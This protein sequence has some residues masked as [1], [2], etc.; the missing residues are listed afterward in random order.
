MDQNLISGTLTPDDVQACKDALDVLFTKMPFLSAMQNVDVSRFFKVG[1]AYQPLLDLAMQ[2]VETH[3]EILPLI[4]DKEEFM[5]DS[6]LYAALEP[7]SMRVSEL[8]TGLDK[9]VMAVGS[10][11]LKGAREVYAAVKQHKNK[12]PGLSAVYD[13]MSAFFKKNKIKTTPA[14]SEG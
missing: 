7:L 14:S 9:T 3:P 1:T 13:E 10:D 6:E 4:F 5:R 12:V 2:V 8:H 11:T